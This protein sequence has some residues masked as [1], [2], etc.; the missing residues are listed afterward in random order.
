MV[1]ADTSTCARSNGIFVRYLTGTVSKIA[2]S[3]MGVKTTKKHQE[4]RNNNNPV[5]KPL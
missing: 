2:A 1:N 3:G 4:N 5:L